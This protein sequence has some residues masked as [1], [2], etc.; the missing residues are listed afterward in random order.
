[1]SHSEIHLICLFFPQ[2]LINVSISSTSPIKAYWIISQIVKGRI[3]MW[4]LFEIPHNTDF[5]SPIFSF[6][7]NK[8][9]QFSTIYTGLYKST[10]SITT[11]IININTS[12]HSWISS[13]WPWMLNSDIHIFSLFLIVKNKLLK[14]IISGSHDLFWN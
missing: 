4:D 10:F 1:M 9:Q 2:G 6:C 14:F 11:T 7:W 12:F 13:F 5:L 3:R 8:S